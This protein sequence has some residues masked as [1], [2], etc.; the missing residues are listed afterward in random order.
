[1]YTNAAA[2]INGFVIVNHPAFHLKRAAPYDKYAA[3]AVHILRSLSFIALNST[4]CH[5]QGA[6]ADVKT[7]TTAAGA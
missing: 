4:S 2:A 1:V 3:A 7:A 5:L 6:V